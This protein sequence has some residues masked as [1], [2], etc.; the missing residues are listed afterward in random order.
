MAVDTLIIMVRLG[1]A[2]F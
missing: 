1:R 2:V